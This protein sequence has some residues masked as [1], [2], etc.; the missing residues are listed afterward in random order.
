MGQS[1]FLFLQKRKN[2]EVEMKI[3]GCV[4]DWANRFQMIGGVNRRCV[5][6]DKIVLKMRFSLRKKHLKSSRLPLFDS[7]KIEK[8]DNED[9]A[10]EDVKKLETDTEIKKKE[11]II[12]RRELRNTIQLPDLA[13]S[14]NS[15]GRQSC[16]VGVA[17]ILLLQSCFKC[18]DPI[19]GMIGFL[20][21]YLDLTIGAYLKDYVT[22]YIALGLFPL[23]NLA[24]ISLRSSLSKIVLEDER[25]KT[26]F[27][28]AFV[29]VAFFYFGDLLQSQVFRY[30][31]SEAYPIL[32]YLL[33]STFLI[34]ALCTFVF[35]FISI[36]TEHLFSAAYRN[37]PIR[38]Y[39]R[40]KD[41]N[42]VF[43]E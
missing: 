14:I 11:S 22:F 31:G 2:R 34:I 1:K 3:T 19:I 18:R 23:K 26:F 15:A 20:N 4:C 24:A 39:S 6:V 40:R 13:L 21:L 29:E 7:Y 9:P 36:D 38:R 10:W 32:S 27:L 35:Q 25:G 30:L 28:L 17:A 12:R 42:D 16:G 37:I 43:A 33:V 8:Y 41:E 5:K